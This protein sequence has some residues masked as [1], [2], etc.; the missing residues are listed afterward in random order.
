MATL[1][2]EACLPPLATEKFVRNPRKHDRLPKHSILVN[3]F[4]LAEATA[5][6]LVILAVILF[7]LGAQFWVDIIASAHTLA[8]TW[9]AGAVLDLKRLHNYVPTLTQCF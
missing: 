7:Q 8:Q 4:T 3:K 2:G 9:K 1:V 5:Y 6:P